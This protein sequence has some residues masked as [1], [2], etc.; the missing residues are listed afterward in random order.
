MTQVVSQKILGRE[1]FYP[2]FKTA[3]LALA[4]VSNTILIQTGTNKQITANKKN[5]M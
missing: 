3:S 1:K 5:A 4:S 2:A